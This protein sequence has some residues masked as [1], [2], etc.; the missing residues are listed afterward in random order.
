MS[1]IGEAIK[2][3]SN[4]IVPIDD[5]PQEEDSQCCANDPEETPPRHT[6]QLQ[7]CKFWGGANVKCL[8]AL[9]LALQAQNIAGQKEA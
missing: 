6:L 7:G 4:S 3:T 1:D 8:S 5:W 9:E 2:C